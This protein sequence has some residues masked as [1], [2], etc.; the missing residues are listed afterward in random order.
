MANH[1]LGGVVHIRQ[2]VI[3][4]VDKFCS[5]II[6]NFRQQNQHRSPAEDYE[7]ISATLFKL[8]ECKRRDFPNAREFARCGV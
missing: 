3:S 7:S 6:L 8:I 4:Q 1:I 2:L 5:H